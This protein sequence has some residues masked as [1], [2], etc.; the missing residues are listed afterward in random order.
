MTTA[1]ALGV[2]FSLRSIP[3]GGGCVK[4]MDISMFTVNSHPGE[5]T[6]YQV[7][8][9][10]NTFPRGKSSH[11]DSEQTNLYKWSIVNMTQ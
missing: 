5:M 7:A 9:T 2:S 8:Q 6:I 1:F 10:S 11:F 4:T 3:S